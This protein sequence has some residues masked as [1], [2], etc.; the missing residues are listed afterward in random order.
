MM[1]LRRAVGVFLRPWTDGGATFQE[2]LLACAV[3][4]DAVLRD[5]QQRRKTTKSLSTAQGEG[6]RQ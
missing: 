1:T 5:E 2:W 3:I 4:N 6:P